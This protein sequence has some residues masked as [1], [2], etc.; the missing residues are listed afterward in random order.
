M[1]GWLCSRGAFFFRLKLK[2]LLFPIGNLGKIKP[3]GL[4]LL[5]LYSRRPLH[6]VQ[7]GGAGRSLGPVAGEVVEGARPRTVVPER[8]IEHVTGLLVAE[9]SRNLS[10]Y[11]FYVKLYLN[12]LVFAIQFFNSLAVAQSSEMQFVFKFVVVA[13]LRVS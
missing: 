8:T 5:P 13:V 6:A 4:A 9:H 12:I 3:N 1:M 10:L 2:C 11:W 7:H